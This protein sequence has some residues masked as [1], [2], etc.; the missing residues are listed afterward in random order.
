MKLDGTE[1]PGMRL[2]K[3]MT[4][5]IGRLI[6]GSC[7]SWR[8]NTGFGVAVLVGRGVGCRFVYINFPVKRFDDCPGVSAFRKS[9]RPEIEKDLTRWIEKERVGRY[10]NRHAK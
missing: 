3:V 2:Q 1:R 6:K 5:E 8:Y 7:L 9:I 4:D 10:S